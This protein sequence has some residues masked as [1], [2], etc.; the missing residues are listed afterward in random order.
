MALGFV[1]GRLEVKRGELL[2]LWSLE[3]GSRPWGKRILVKTSRLGSYKP[4]MLP[5]ICGLSSW[6]EAEC[7]LG[8]PAH[9]TLKTTG[10]GVSSLSFSCWKHVVLGQI[11]EG[12]EKPPSSGAKYF[13]E[14]GWV[15]RHTNFT[16]WS[17]EVS[18]WAS[19]IIHTQT[20][21]HTQRIILFP[22]IT[23]QQMTKAP[24]SI[25][26]TESQRPQVPWEYLALVPKPSQ[27]KSSRAV[28]VEKPFHHLL[29]T[30]IFTYL[31][32]PRHFRTPKAVFYTWSR[33]HLCPH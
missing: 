18:T 13:W 24:G 5:D 17:C 29:L 4:P 22:L 21:P 30:C 16:L 31:L 28:L 6:A 1:K 3:L 11:L 10:L 20:F 23:N 15:I 9:G 12:L 27:V 8:R 26:L 7:M 14:I 33:P 19:H 2:T 25:N 32:R